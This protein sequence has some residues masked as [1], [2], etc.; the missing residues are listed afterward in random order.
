[1]QTTPSGFSSGSTDVGSWLESSYFLTGFVNATSLQQL[2][3]VHSYPVQL[4]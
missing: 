1:M 4:G 3:A 2:I